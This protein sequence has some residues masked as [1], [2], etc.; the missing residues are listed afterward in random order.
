M[1]R[2]HHF[3]LVLTLL[4]AS[5]LALVLTAEQPACADDVLQIAGDWDS[6]F[7][8]GKV[9][10]HMEQDGVHIKGKYG[11]GNPGRIDGTLNGKELK[12][13]WV[14][15]D[16]RG[17]RFVFMFKHDHEFAGQWGDGNSSS[18]GGHWNGKR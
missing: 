10:L 2:I 18:S 5:P 16:G 12:G 14:G 11:G 13:Q 6:F 9:P 17:G 3:P 7:G 4:V 1:R 8:T 15:D